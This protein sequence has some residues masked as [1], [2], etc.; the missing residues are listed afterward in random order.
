MFAHIAIMWV[1]FNLILSGINKML[2]FVS[3]T[4]LPFK[5]LGTALTRSSN[6]INDL[7][8]SSP[9]ITTDTIPG[10]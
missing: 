6:N 1:V 7:F 8:S 5:V 3:N 2:D 4:S 10:T 9:P